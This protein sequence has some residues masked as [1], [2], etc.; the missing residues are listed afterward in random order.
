MDSPDH[1]AADKQPIAVPSPRDFQPWEACM[2]INDTWAYRP[3]DRNFKSA[4]LLIRSMVE[5][6]SRGGNF[7]LDVGPQPDGQIQPE[8]VERLEAI[9]SWV[10]K[11]AAAVYGSTYGPIQGEP[12]YRTTARADSVYVFVMDTSFSEIV[13]KGLSRH[14]AHVTLLSN[15]RHLPFTATAGTI[16]ISVAGQMW[17]DGIP[18]LEMRG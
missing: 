3:K 17:A 16:R 14:I 4:D 9:G 18:V 10:G 11:N 12:G 8:F 13:I 15:G 6:L 2:T 5:I 1:S 7:L